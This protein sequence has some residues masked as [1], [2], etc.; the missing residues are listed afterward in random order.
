MTSRQHKKLQ[1]NKYGRLKVMA[2]HG[3]DK[4][5]NALWFCECDCGGIKVL[6][7]STL[8]NGVTKSCGCIGK[9]NPSHLIHGGCGTRLY[10][11]WKSMNKRCNKDNAYTKNYGHRGI[12]VCKEWRN[13]F[14]TFRQWALSNGYSENLTIDRLDNKGNNEP[15]NCR[16][17]T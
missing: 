6:N 3:R 1:G 15:D 11:I 5:G 7:T 14:T 17:A 16:W 4:R 2:Y 9:E 8:V 12:K 13:S 10:S